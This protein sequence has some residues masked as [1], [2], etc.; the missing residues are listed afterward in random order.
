MDAS[1][2]CDMSRTIFDHCDIDLVSRII[3][4]GAYLYYLR[5]EYHIWRVYSSWDGEVVH[6]ILVTFTLTLTSDLSLRFFVSGECLLYY[7]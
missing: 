1:L 3:M 7:K 2:D 6:T 5:Q 4:S